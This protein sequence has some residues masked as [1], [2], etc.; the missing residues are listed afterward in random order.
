MSD[1]LLFDGD[2]GSALVLHFDMDAMQS[3]MIK[4]DPECLVLGYTHTMMGFLFFQPEPERIEMIGLGGGSLAKYCLRYLPDAHFTAIEINPKV[5][6]LRNQFSIP[7]D[8]EHFKVICAK[9]ADYVRNHTEKVDV[10]LIDGFKLNGQPESLSSADFY[11]NCYAKLN[12]GGVMVVNLLADDNHYD[13]YT[14]RIRNSFKNK[15]LLV[16][17]E[18][19]GNKI[20]F[21]CKG[22]NFPPSF[23]DIQKLVCALGPKHRLPLQSIAQKI[24]LSIRE[25]AK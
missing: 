8:N 19:Q 7:P 3:A 20:A 25:T 23:A 16:D 22:D 13:T 15:V 11:N 5:I 14:S 17:A 1:P 6:A 24:F 18:T 12:D 10:L 21:A 9:G 2:G 4:D